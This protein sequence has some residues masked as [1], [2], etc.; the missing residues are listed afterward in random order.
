MRVNIIVTPPDLN[1]IAGR[2]ARELV[3]RLPKHGIEA[4]INESRGADL[5]YQQIVYGPPV[6]RPAVGLFTHGRDRP[7]RFAMEY[8]G[9]ISMNSK[10]EQYLREAGSR[11]SIVIEQPVDPVFRKPQV[12]FGVAGRTYADGR[13]GEHLVA[14][15]VESGYRVIA[16]GHGWP[17]QIVSAKLEDLPLFYRT[18]D[19]YIDTSS[20][21]GGCTPALEAMAMGVP[22]IS[23][24]LGVDRPVLSYQTHD[25]P[26]LEWVL[27]KLT[28]PCTYDDWAAAHARYFEIVLRYAIRKGEVLA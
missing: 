1:W 15:M 27:R 13:K 4:R 7:I 19:Y 10:M 8:D 3:A 24:T 21:E 26:S 12:V 14:K 22:V 20:D 2:F 9:C 6:T 25:W 17:C 5:E 18:I 28:R 11:T 16:W 23:H